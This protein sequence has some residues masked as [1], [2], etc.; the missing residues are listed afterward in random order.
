VLNAAGG[1][2]T[3]PD[4]APFLYGKA[5]QGFRNGWFVARGDAQALVGAAAKD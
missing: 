5:D 3:Q 1:A 4:R 2:L